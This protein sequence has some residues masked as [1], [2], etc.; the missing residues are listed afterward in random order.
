MALEIG[1]EDF[2][3]GVEITSLEVAS[4]APP[5]PVLD[6]FNAVQTARIDQETLLEEALGEREETLIAAEAQAAQE[7]AEARGLREERI[8]QASKQVALFQAA[9]SLALKVSQPMA[10]ET[11]RREAMEM[12][13]RN[14]RRVYYLP[15][16]E[17]TRHL[18]VL[19]PEAKA[20]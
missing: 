17:N 8:S 18:R 2:H 20:R 14:A 10:R 11:M 5:G 7:I 19:L 4:I 3:L 12:S 6:A 13:L 15:A 9:R 16:D 1:C